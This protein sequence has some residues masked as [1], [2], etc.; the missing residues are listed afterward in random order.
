MKCVCFKKLKG[1]GLMRSLKI[2]IHGF[3]LSKF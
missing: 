2:W 3:K 1:F